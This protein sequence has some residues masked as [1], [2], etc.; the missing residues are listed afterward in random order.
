MTALTI[1]DL[2][3]EE[4]LVAGRDVHGT[5]SIGVSGRVGAVGGVPEK[6]RAAA[7]AGADLVLVPAAQLEE[8]ERAAPEDVAVVGVAT[9]DDAIE[10]LRSTP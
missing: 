2:L 3:A 7:A 4:D 1:Y 8:A 10:A 6:V 5:G 9:L